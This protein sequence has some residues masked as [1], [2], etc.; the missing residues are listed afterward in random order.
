M[1]ECVEGGRL[2]GR[3]IPRMKGRELTDREVLRDGPNSGGLHCREKLLTRLYVPV[4]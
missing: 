1:E 2:Y 4:P 3:Q